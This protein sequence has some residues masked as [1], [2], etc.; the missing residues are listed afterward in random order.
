ML[1]VYSRQAELVGSWRGSRRDIPDR[2]T[3]GRAGNAIIDKWALV[4]IYDF[5][6]SDAHGAIDSRTPGNNGRMCRNG[7]GSA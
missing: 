1:L 4:N 2:I 7:T 3:A 6:L 5:C